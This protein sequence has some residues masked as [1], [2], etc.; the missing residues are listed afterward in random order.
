MKQIVKQS[1]RGKNTLDLLFTNI[2]DLYECPKTL[3]ALST[4]D[5]NVIEWNFKRAEKG[6][7]VKIKVRPITTQQVDD[8]NTA[9]YN[10]D[11]SPATSILKISME[12][13]MFFYELL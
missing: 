13:L 4:S 9:L 1:T 12:K 6:N 11:W 7:K 5:H 8:F 2:A 10:H 3:A